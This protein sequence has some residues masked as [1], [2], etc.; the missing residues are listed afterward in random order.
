MMLETSKFIAH[1]L[2]IL[3]SSPEYPKGTHYKIML[4]SF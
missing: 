4:S 3:N 1:L 2:N